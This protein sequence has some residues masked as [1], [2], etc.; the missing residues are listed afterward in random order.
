M[1]HISDIPTRNDPTARASFRS[2]LSHGEDSID[3]ATWAGGIAPRPAIA[4]RIRIGKPGKDRW[5]NLLWLIPI[6]FVLLLAGIA[7]ATWLRSLPAVEGFIAAYPGEHFN[8][9][10]SGAVGTPWWLAVQ[11]FVNILFMTFIIRSGWQILTDHPRL[12]WTRNSKPGVEWMRIAPKAPDDPLWTAKQ[13]S[14]ELPAQVGLP[15]VRHSIGLARWWH[16]TMDLGWLVN[17]VIFYVLLFAT[18]QWRKIVPTSWDVFPNALSTLIQY[19]SLDFPT[20][21]G[22][23]AYNGLQLLAYFVTVF[24]AAPLAMITGL[25][26]SPALSTRLHAISKRFSIQ[27]A[28]SMHA[29]I[30]VW[31]VVF[32]I[33]HV[34]MVFSTG[35][36]QNL[37]A[38]FAARH[39]TG[40][41]GVVVFALAMVVVIV[42]WVWASPFTMKHPRTVQKVGDA[43][44]GPIQFTFMYCGPRGSPTAH[45][46]SPR[47]K[48]S[49]S[50]PALPPYSVW[51]SP[52]V[53]DRPLN[54]YS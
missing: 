35:A 2:E 4:P 15:G 45:I 52:T 41:A 47:M 20:N 30:M 3:R 16:L 40:P 31:F 8:D 48:C 39:S 7:V 22:W 12:Y 14:V 34:T 26:M 10:D 19:A 1:T 24:V 36:A 42:T 25:G 28:R 38:M 53:Y 21:N 5:F 44:V 37:N 46:S 18:G 9:P 6:G 33:M 32:I 49:Q 17:G 11:H 27:L 50:S 51:V 29:L 43:I 13:D 23:L 54:R